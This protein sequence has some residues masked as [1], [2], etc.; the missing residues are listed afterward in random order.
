MAL[1]LNA[2]DLHAWPIGPE[3]LLAF[4]TFGLRL[5]MKKMKRYPRVRMKIS[6]S[7]VAVTLHFA[8]E[9]HEYL[10]RITRDLPSFA[11]HVQL[12]VVTNVPDEELHRQIRARVSGLNE[13]DIV[14]PN[15]LGHP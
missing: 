4:F 9:R 2:A 6:K 7:L 5:A 14:A 8:P 1:H 10:K 12:V 13:V 11:D 15:L 3:T